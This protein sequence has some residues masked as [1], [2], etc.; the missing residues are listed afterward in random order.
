MWQTRYHLKL[1][2]LYYLLIIYLM[3]SKIIFW[4]LILCL[5]AISAIGMWT[6]YASYCPSEARVYENGIKC[7]FFIPLSS[8]STL[9]LFLVAFF[10]SQFLFFYKLTQVSKVQTSQSSYFI[11]NN[12]NETSFV[13]EKIPLSRLNWLKVKTFY[14][15]MV[16]YIKPNIYYL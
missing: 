6:P 3:M 16:N 2:V 13:G 8:L 7:H 4:H 14:N 15:P 10:F 5:L 11:I 9:S 12:V 1:L